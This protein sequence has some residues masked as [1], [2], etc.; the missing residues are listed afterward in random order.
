[1]HGGLSMAV[2]AVLNLSQTTTNASALIHCSGY[3]PPISYAVDNEWIQCQRGISSFYLRSYATRRAPLG[4]LGLEQGC[5]QY[6]TLEVLSTEFHR[7]G[8]GLKSAQPPTEDRRIASIA[9]V[10]ACTPFLA[11]RPF[12]TMTTPTRRHCV[13]SIRRIS[14]S[15]WTLRQR[16]FL[17]VSSIRFL[18]PLN[19]F[20]ALYI[21][22]QTNGTHLYLSLHDTFGSQCRPT[23]PLL[24]PQDEQT[25]IHSRRS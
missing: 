17:P 4:S 8:R 24:D 9:F 25:K 10:Q 19:S 22:M 12:P 6:P 23:P 2:H 3:R 13:R 5:Y 16:A 1:M 18:F 15:N 14:P 7:L 11:A 20:Y 21:S